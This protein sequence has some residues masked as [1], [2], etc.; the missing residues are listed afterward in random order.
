M[1]A[2][3]QKEESTAIRPV[4][5]KVRV[6]NP[7]LLSDL[8]HEAEKAKQ[9]QTQVAGALN[10][11]LYVL[12][13][14]C[15]SCYLLLL[16]A[17]VSDVTCLTIE[18]QYTHQQCCVIFMQGGSQDASPSRPTTRP[19]TEAQDFSQSDG[20]QKRIDR[21]KLLKYHELNRVG[22]LTRKQLNRT[23]QHLSKQRETSFQD[24][25]DQLQHGLTSQDGI[26]SQV[27]DILQQSASVKRQKKLQL[28]SEWDSQVKAQ[29]GLYTRLQEPTAS[30]MPHRTCR[31]AQATTV[32]HFI[33]SPGSFKQ[34]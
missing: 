19:S 24:S 10:C 12:A 9:Q 6:Y 20:L 22:E 14:K 30:R 8:L 21:M 18:L 2:V 34:L 31:Q 25:F 16:H 26:I 3:R 5:Q 17:A 29:L 13:A 32:Q 23:M 15:Y 4:K 11:L 27:N 28:F 33:D 7:S 1:R